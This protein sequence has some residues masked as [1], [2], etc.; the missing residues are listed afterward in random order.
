MGFFVWFCLFICFLLL[1][2]FCG[3]LCGVFLPLKIKT[4]VPVDAFLQCESLGT[5]DEVYHFQSAK[6]KQQV[7]HYVARVALCLL[8]DLISN[9]LSS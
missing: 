9:H 5:K 7:W 4:E 6:V 3:F 1:F 2:G 8:L